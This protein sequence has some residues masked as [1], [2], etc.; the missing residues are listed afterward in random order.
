MEELQHRLTTA[1]TEAEGL[2][3]QIS[4]SDAAQDSRHFA[5][6]DDLRCAGSAQLSS[7]VAAVHVARGYSLMHGMLCRGQ[8][9]EMQVENGNLKQEL[10]A[11]DPAFW[12]ELEDLKHSHH[13]L[14][15]K[16]ASYVARFGPVPA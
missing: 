1:L 2:R 12:E 8:L 13:C 15:E 5:E 11:F 14:Q 6:Q 4:G 3:D 16:C 7:G 9:R 10:A